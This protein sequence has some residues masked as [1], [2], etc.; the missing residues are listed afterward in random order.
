M[1]KKIHKEIL[2]I[3][4]HKGNA[5]IATLRF[6]LTPVRIAAMKNTNNNKY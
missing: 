5:I 6:H 4:G 3:P 1:A 2:T